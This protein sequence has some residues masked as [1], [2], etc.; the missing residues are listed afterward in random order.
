MIAPIPGTIGRPTIGKLAAIGA[1]ADGKPAIGGLAGGAAAIG[2]IDPRYWTRRAAC[3]LEP[4]EC[5]PATPNRLCDENRAPTGATAAGTPTFR[6][7]FGIA[8]SLERSSHAPPR[9]IK[10][11]LTS[12]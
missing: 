8:T 9:R 1:P 12:M 6:A 4:D 10:A 3:Y 5:G 11:G 7:A 2:A